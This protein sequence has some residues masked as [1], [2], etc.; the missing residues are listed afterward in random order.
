MATVTFTDEQYLHQYFHY[1][2]KHMYDG[3]ERHPKYWFM[4][5]FEEPLDPEY[6]CDAILS[7]AKRL[8]YQ[9]KKN[10]WEKL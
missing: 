3:L 9:L 4:D 5:G 7:L 1:Y 2:L 8:G 10:M 6:L